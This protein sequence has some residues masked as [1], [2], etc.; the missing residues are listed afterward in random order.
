MNPAASNASDAPPTFQP[1]SSPD[2]VPREQLRGLQ[3]QRLREV[4]CRAYEHVPLYRQRMQKHGL[5]P[6]EIRGADDLPR[7][8][9]TLP[10]DL[11]DA[12]PFG[13]FAVPIQQ[14]LRLHFAG[15][16]TGKPIVAAYTRRDLEVW[17]EVLL[18]CLACCGVRAGD[19]IQHACGHDQPPA[20]LGLH[21]AAAALGAAVLSL[22]AGDPLRQI[23]AL[24]DCGVS[25]VCSTP[26]YFLHLLKRAEKLG[27]DLRGLPLRAGI[28]IAEP[29]GEALR[30]RIEE[31]AGIKAYEIYGP[32]E[33]TGPGVGAECRHQTGLHIFEDHFYPEIVDPSTGDPLPAGQEGELVLTT[34]SK[35]AMPVIRY[36]TRERAAILAEPCPCGRTMRR[37]QRIARHGEDMFVVQGVSVFPAEIEAA[38]LAVE[39]TLP[40]YQ[41]V[42]SQEQGQD[43]VEV[44]VE[45]TPDVFSDRVGAMVAL[46][47]KLAQ[48]I[49]HALGISVAVRLV[50]P[51]T[52]ER[53]QAAAARIIDKRGT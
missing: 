13:M 32:P 25:A 19:I 11:R 44:Q 14:I 2:Y 43:Q 12:Y 29:C 37:I 6:A 34:L 16:G 33:I 46:Q 26:S 49:E 23:M 18:R 47:K 15:G 53:S 28:F 10:S 35:E 3:S 31:S 21:S 40:H 4:V 48:Q 36:R 52:L 30:R 50:E 8:P 42:L 17:T 22:S 39:G 38:L 41:I 20:G 24:K 51:H 45:V 5:T 27:V 1:A 9:F 7:L